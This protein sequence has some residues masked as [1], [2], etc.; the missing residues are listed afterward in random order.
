MPAPWCSWKTVTC[1]HRLLG[2]AEPSWR[3]IADKADDAD[4]PRCWLATP[5]TDATNPSNV[6]RRTP[7]PLDNSA[8]AP[9]T[10][11][12]AG[13]AGWTAGAASPPAATG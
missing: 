1:L 8:Y 4:R 5:G 10:S 13:P 12:G 3:V 6:T 2:A 7:H 9:T 11:S